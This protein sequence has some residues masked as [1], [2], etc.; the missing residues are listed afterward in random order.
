MPTVTVTPNPSPEATIARSIVRTAVETAQPTEVPT[1]TP[2]PRPDDELILDALKSKLGN[3]ATMTISKKS[4]NAAY[5][6]VDLGEEGGYFVAAKDS[7]GN[8]KIIADGNG[9]I[10]CSLLDQYNVPSSV[11]SGCYDS[12]TGEAKTR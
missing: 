5:G 2:K 8:W 10:E 9:T 3:N 6:S 7:S 1:E 12:A 4:D 11:V